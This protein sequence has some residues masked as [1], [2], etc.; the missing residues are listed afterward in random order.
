MEFAITAPV[1][2]R[3]DTL[4]GWEINLQH[5][6]GQSGFGMQ[7]N[8]TYVDSGLTYD[9]GR[10]GTQFAL[11]GLSDSANLVGFYEK[12]PWSIRAAYNWRDKFLSDL[13]DGKGPNPRYTEAYGQLD[14]NL[15]YNVTEALTLSV[16]AINVTNETMR[17]HGRNTRQLYSV[18][19]LGPRYMFGARYKF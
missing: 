8:Y 14:L 6:F 12:G 1:N 19:Q 7:A 13:G 5:V 3:D 2:N 15:S 17:I 4:D 18:D 11:T 16:E 10:L 9:N